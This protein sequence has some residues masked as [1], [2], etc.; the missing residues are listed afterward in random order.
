MPEP[1]FECIECEIIAC[2]PHAILVDFEGEEEWIP[3]SV[4]A[5]G[6]QYGREDIGSVVDLEVEA[7]K[8]DYLGWV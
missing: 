3:R 5:D 8:L 2:S 7:W 4:I 1:R 6:A